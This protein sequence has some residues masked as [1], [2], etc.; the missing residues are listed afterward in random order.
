LEGTHEKR[1]PLVAQPR[2]LMPSCPSFLDG[3]ARATWRQVAP[4]LH[5]L[6]LLTELDGT[7][8]AAFCTAAARWR[9][10][11][12]VL[13][14][15]GLTMIVPQGLLARPEVAIARLE[16][17]AAVR[18][19]AELGL[20]P[21]ARARLGGGAPPDPAKLDLTLGGLLNFGTPPARPRSS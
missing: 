19:G 6:G 11:E 1:K 15:E 20:T 16:R 8:L 18:F 7:I 21:T 5:R 12:R 10:A 13:R 2:P 17:A 14:T 9:A 3:A 4:A